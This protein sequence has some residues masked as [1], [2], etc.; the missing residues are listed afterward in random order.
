MFGRHPNAPPQPTLVVNGIV[1]K[2]DNDEDHSEYVRYEHAR[3]MAEFK[4]YAGAFNR[5]E[6][7]NTRKRLDLARQRAYHNWLKQRG[8]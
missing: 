5:T 6:R 3:T 1:V 8:E 7:A 2:F 4:A